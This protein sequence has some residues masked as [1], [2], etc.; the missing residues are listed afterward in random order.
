MSKKPMFTP[1]SYSVHDEALKE[2]SAEDVA[3]AREEV[4]R[5]LAKKNKRLRA[6]EI[7]WTIIS[8]IFAI[9][10][11]AILLTKNWVDGVVSYV[12]LSILIVYVLVFIVLCAMIYRHPDSGADI[13]I[14]G[15]AIK[16][17]KALANIAF[18]V[19]TAMTMAAL[20]KENH[21]LN[22]AQ[23]VIFFGNMIVAGVK[24]VLKIV[25][26]V[27]YLLMRHTAKNYSIRVTRYV[28]GEQQKKTFMDK[29]EEKKYE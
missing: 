26:L 28:D 25:S 4:E 8:T 3:R 24:L 15:K 20:V 16:I 2:Y 14:Y 21:T 7:A 23:W 9:I 27:R 18:L 29:H 5:E 12:I 11:T 13:K 10:S 17:F 6:F 22:L 19:L 1:S